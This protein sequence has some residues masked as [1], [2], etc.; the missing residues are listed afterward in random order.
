MNNILVAAIVLIAC[1]IAFGQSSS[2]RQNSSSS[3]QIAEIDVIIRDLPADYYGFNEFDYNKGNSRECSEGVTKNMVR[4]SLDYSK[5]TQADLVGEAG[6][7]IPMYR[8]GRYCARPVPNPTPPS[9]MCYGENLHEWFTDS[10]KVKSVN[11]LMTLTRRSDG[12]Y[13]IIYN[14][15]TRTDWNGYGESPGYFPLDKYDNENPRDPV[16]YNLDATWG[17]QSLSISCNLPSSSS[18]SNNSSSSTNLSRLNNCDLWLYFGGPKVNDAAKKTVAERDSLQKYLHN[19]G[20]TVAGSAEFKYVEA[21]NDK[22]AFTGD[23]D[24]W[25]FIDGNLVIDL[26]GVHNAVDGEVNI[27]DVAKQYKWVDGSR[28]V[29]NFYYAERQTTESNLRLRFAL[30]DLSPP[31]FGAPYILEAQTSINSDGTG[32]TLIWV[33]TKLSEESIK[34]FIGSDQFPIL[35][36]KSDPNNKVL[37]AYK[38]E[39]ISEPRVDG[40]KGFIY[41]IT[42]QVCET[43]T[44]CS[45]KFIIGSGDSLSFNVKFGDIEGYTD[46]GFALPDG[47]D[48]W[49][50]KST[51]NIPATKLQWGPNTTKMPPV[52]FKPIPGDDGPVK[53]IFDMDVWFTGDPKG[54][55]SGGECASC[56][57][58]PASGPFPTINGQIWDP[59][60]GDF[61]H[62]P[63]ASTTVHG[64]GQK[65]TPIPL[66][67]AGELVLTA[68]PS[69]TGI[70]NTINGPMTY[71]EWK[72]NEKM[73]K[74]FGLPPTV[75]EYG[76]FGV[77]NPQEQAMDGGWAFV[78]NGF[79]DESSA[80]G[81]GQLAP[82]RCI[83]DRSKPDE[84]RINCLN[85][86]LLAQQPFQINV[87]VFDQFG[88]FVTQ[89]RETVT[90]REFRSVV[91]GPNYLEE[92]QAAV[93]ELSKNA[94]KDCEEPTSSNY[95][96]PTVLT[97]NGLVKVNVNIYPFSANGRR[98]GNGV[99]IVKIDRIDLPYEGCV[100]NAGRPT[101]VNLGYIRYHAEQKFGWMRA[102][103]KD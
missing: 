67:R 4:D 74:L 31:R 2:S 97:T 101:P 46:P 77:A 56:G 16:Y 87:A 45:N 81:K 36:R 63:N 58:L 50:V 47:T 89:Y 100:N 66:N 30:S 61:V 23:D 92:N 44:N 38:L 20:F 88:N 24:M 14:K 78:K 33:S 32:K 69:A 55:T 39:T 25:V 9:K 85:F 52:E 93:E 54:G 42:G 34:Q 15:D 28:H 83:A 64:F 86:S 99:Y 22:F 59:V 95:G 48:T 49:Y 51:G 10:G 27:N 11:E 68:F 12:L 90:E 91:Q 41:E 29:I 73:Q 102:K 53:P 72:E 6:D 37:Y 3:V 94:S 70:V 1:T 62:V 17:K 13:E 8:K 103:S 79:K 84:P 60:I 21:N 18:S 82:T 35:I 80:G 5:C 26:G 71:E 7:S 76:P 43:K 98:F 75:S 65:G 40:S 57:S 96:K 19:F